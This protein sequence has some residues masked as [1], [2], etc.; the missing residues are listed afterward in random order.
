[1]DEFVFAGLAMIAV[2]LLAM[3][4]MD[5]LAPGD[6]PVASPGD[7][8]LHRAVW[9]AIAFLITPTMAVTM[10]PATPPPTA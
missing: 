9:P 2:T 4:V 6:A 7:F 10:A 3:S 5:V 1:M 8:V